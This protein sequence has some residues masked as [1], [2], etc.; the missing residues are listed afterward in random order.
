MLSLLWVFL[1]GDPEVAP[2]LT[3]EERE[4]CLAFRFGQLIKSPKIDAVGNASN[5]LL[6]VAE[7]L[8]DRKMPLSAGTIMRADKYPAGELVLAIER[9]REDEL[10]ERGSERFSFHCCGFRGL[11]FRTLLYY[12]GNAFI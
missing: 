5:A 12:K 8:H 9:E 11:I 1:R 4:N 2:G 10:A 7:N 3:L 6:P